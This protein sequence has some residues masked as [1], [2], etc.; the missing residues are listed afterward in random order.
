MLVRD[1]R[2]IFNT[3]KHSIACSRDYFFPFPGKE[4]KNEAENILYP[5]EADLTRE[6]WACWRPSGKTIIGQE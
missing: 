4:T 6:V 3:F 5:G 2:A 1:A